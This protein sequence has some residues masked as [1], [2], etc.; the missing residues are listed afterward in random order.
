VSARKAVLAAMA[1][2]LSA[3]AVG[4]EKKSAPATIGDLAKRPVEIRKDGP[5]TPATAGRAME[6]YRRFLDLKRTDPKMRA[7]ALRRLGDLSLESGE[8]ER[9][10]SEVT[11]VDLGGAEAIRLYTT[12]LAAH[13]DYPRN[14]QVL[15]Q[16]ARAYETTGQ[17]EKALAT[18][19][20]IGR[21]Y[22][23]ARDQDEVQFRRGELLF[24]AQ[25]YRDAETAYA[26]VVRAGD[27]RPY[28]QQALYK[29]GWALFKQSLNEESLPVFARLL[30]LKLRD[31]A[32]ADGLRRVESLPR[33]DRELVDDTLRVMAVTFSYM[34][35]TQ[36]LDAFVTRLG[37]PPYAALLYSRLGDLY[38]DKQ[39]FQDAAAVYRAFVARQPNSEFAPGLAMQ[40]IE[41]Y[42]KGGFAQLVLE[43]KR[44]YVERY[45]FDAPF[46]QGRDRARYPQVVTELKTNLVDVSAWYHAGAQKSHRTED[47]LQAARWYRQ[48]LASFPQEADSARTNYL[49]S[50]ALFEGGEF[51][52]AAT[53]YER[54][55]YD[56]PRG[57]DSA[58]AAYAALSAYAKQEEKLPVAER[59]AWHRRSVDAG[60]RFAQT[61]PEHGD[62]AGV[63]TRAAQD[64]FAAKEGQRAAEV[65]QLLLARDPPAEPARRRIANTI[66]GQVS[67]DAG[68]FAA[69]ESAWTQARE[70]IP[71]KDPERVALN[72]QIAGAVYRQAEVRRK[73][74]DEA[75][76]VDDFLRVAAAAPGAAVLATAKYDAAAALVNLKQWP[77]AIEVLEG[78]RRDYPKSDFQADVTQKL[79]VAYQES[80]RATEAAG[81]FERI[82]ARPGE[83]PALRMEALQTAAALYERSGNTPRAVQLLEK[84][85]AEFPAPFAARVEDR[86]KLADIAAKAGN[87]ERQRYWQR[88]IIKADAAAG[89]ARTDRSRYLAAR[90]SLAMATPARDAFR[91]VRLTAPLNKSLAN[92]RKAL[93]TA[94]TDY[95]TA[96][97]YEIAEV[98]TAASFE[99]AE[100]Y[101]VLAKD[102]LGSER[103][104]KLSADA[105]EQ[106]DLLLEEQAF[107]F[108]EQAI[109]LHESNAARAREG[110]YDDGVRGSYAALAQLSPARYGKSELPGGYVRTVAL[111]PMTPESLPPRAAA[112][113]D[114]AVGLAEAG[115]ATDAEL[116]FRQL[117]LTYPNQGGA[118]L[119]AGLLARA[120]GRGEEAETA[121]RDVVQREPGSALGWN[122]LGLT[123]RARGKFAEARDAYQHALE[124]APQMAP[125][126]RN[127]GVLQDLYLDAPVDALASFERYKALTSE[128]KPVTGW[129]AELR[130]RTGIKAV[131]AA[132]PAAETPA[133]AAAPAE[134]VK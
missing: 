63:L 116:E 24:S 104:A 40:A 1:L 53:E 44:E 28:Y 39:R 62:A 106:Y 71:A 91:A 115:R 76:A 34:D 94:L 72:E 15:Y 26:A 112:D 3:A 33:A 118:L 126:W 87:A 86:Q 125:A 51:A 113:L 77:R 58:K 17:P 20:E 56:Y 122:E 29:Q 102:L 93:E 38:V 78:L 42:R 61:F 84:L 25:K 130:Q 12:L 96:A 81:E 134:E 109:K 103:P 119:N 35:G 18:L 107:P 101:R 79:A 48:T 5:V 21:R 65:A 80:G 114:R 27:T 75:G 22:P 6:N 66:V 49:L 121:L 69:A 36:P 64:L 7:D 2:A 52:Q 108:E 128:D 46:W 67:F 13:P 99:T 32:A 8:L 60:V 110:L 89:A 59:A 16:L 85:V 54:T 10:E 127:L 41:A 124:L 111:G 83:T 129:I 95:R 82:A 73:A 97:A 43:G 68:D 92:K 120:A 74:G 131:P 88:E 105:R 30:D 123:L 55:A 133:P 47:F 100:L 23:Q 14:D 9:M 11:R 117:A 132:A 19:D 37:D 31:P 45:N 50:D 98:T 57:A 4:A 90:A 70:L